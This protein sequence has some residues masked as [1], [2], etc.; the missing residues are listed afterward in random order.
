MYQSEL[1]E[2]CNCNRT[3]TFNFRIPQALKKALTDRAQ[4]TGKKP[5]AIVRE[6]IKTYL[7]DNKAA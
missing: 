2:L 1:V 6:A 7:F 5:S 4:S 3:Q